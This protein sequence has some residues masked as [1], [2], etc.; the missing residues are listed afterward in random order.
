MSCNILRKS[1]STNIRGAGDPRIKEASD[2]MAQS[3]KTAE[4]H[5][6]IRNKQK[7]NNGLPALLVKKTTTNKQ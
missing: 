7:C 4:T 1:A 6:V 3:V 5:Y 2:L